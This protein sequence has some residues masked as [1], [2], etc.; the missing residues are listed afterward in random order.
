MVCDVLLHRTLVGL[1]LETHLVHQCLF[2]ININLPTRS[3][4]LHPTYMLNNSIY[5]TQVVQA[6]HIFKNII[7][8]DTSP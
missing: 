1:A 7:D 3:H 6:N 8:W 4:D 5:P 2:L